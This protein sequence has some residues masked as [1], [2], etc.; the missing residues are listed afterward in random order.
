MRIAI[1]NNKG[2]SGKTAVTVNV[3]DALA[4]RG[5][6]VLVCDLDPQANASR[7]LGW[8][9]DRTNP[10]P[11][12]VEAIHAGTEGAAA[13]AFTPIGWTTSH[14]DR[15]TLAPA[16]FDLENR[17]SEAGLPG[18]VGRLDR[19]L[20]GADDDYDVTFIDCPPSLGHLTQLALVAADVAVVTV[21]PERDG[22]EGA[23]R[24][25]DFIHTNRKLIGNPDL[26]LVGAIPCRVRAGLNSHEHH[27]AQLPELFGNILWGPGIPERTLIKDAADEAL[28]LTEL[29]SRAS[30][31]IAIYDDLAERLIKETTSS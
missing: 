4:R 30:E 7:R 15:I 16:R 31:V 24:F 17:V 6:R 25:R 28:P 13:D 1:G 8:T 26:E 10:R 21:E 11:T 3:A 12:L 20:D 27:M 5:A 9:W 14:A 22:L 29:G 19:A 18:A 2:G 23:V